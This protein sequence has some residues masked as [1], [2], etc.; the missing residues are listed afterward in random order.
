MKNTYQLLGSFFFVI[1]VL[2]VV[3]NRA[4]AQAVTQ[5]TLTTAGITYQVSADIP[6]FLNTG[7]P[8]ADEAAFEAAKS[9]WLAVN[10]LDGSA[11]IPGTY[12]EIHQADFDAL[13][14]NKRLAIAANS[15]YQ[16]IP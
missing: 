2:L 8:A 13:P 9:T 16:I 11:W 3:Q 1:I 6:V 4:N 12:I 10:Q 7:N 15:F 14:A 5:T